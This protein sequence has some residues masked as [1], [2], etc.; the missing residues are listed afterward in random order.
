MLLTQRERG[1]DRLAELVEQQRI[2]ERLLRKQTFR[3]PR[4]EHNIELPPA[5]F[6]DGPDK[7]ASP[8]PCGRLASEKS[9]PV[10]EDFGCFLQSHGSDL[11][12]GSKLRQH[13]EYR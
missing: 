13:R 9:Q 3:E 1:G 12:H 7:H 6:F 2:F 4:Q 8:P 11:A 10:A 5:G